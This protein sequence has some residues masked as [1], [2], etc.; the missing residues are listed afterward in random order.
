MLEQPQFGSLFAYQTG[1]TGTA[2][3]GL[4]FLAGQS[5]GAVFSV[6]SEDEIK[7]ASTAH[8]KRPWQ[9]KSIDAAGARDIL[10]AGRVQWVYPGQTITVV[11]RGNVDENIK[12][13]FQ[14][15]NETKTVTLTPTTIESELASRMYGQVSVGQLESLGSQVFDV[16]AAY[17]RHFRVTGKT[18]SLLMLESEADYERFDIKPKE[19]L[20]VVKAKS[21]SKLVSETL[22]KFAEQL[23][24][25]K[26][27]L[28]TWLSRLESMPGMQFKI[29]TALKLAMDDIEIEA[30]S[31]PLNCTLT[32]KS[33]L[34][35]SYLK[36]I[37]NENLDY[38]PISAEAN[39]RASSSVDDAIKV[40]SSLVE[41]NPSDII[42]ARDIAFTA[43][44][45]E[46]PAPAFHLLRR[47]ARARPFQGN[48]YPA[49]GQCLT[50]MGKADM[51][52]VYYEIAMNGTFQRQGEDFKQIV[53]AEYIHLLR[54]IVSG[55]L[56]SSVKDF[57]AARLETLGKHLPFGTADVVVTMM[58][59]Q[60][61]TDVDMHVVE[62]SGE[63]CYYKHKKTRS[64]GQITSDIT[65]GFGP[66]MY[67]NA[68]A[69]RGKYQLKA[70]FF[71]SG[72]NRTSTR[73]K[74]YVTIIRGFGT[75]SETIDRQTI[76]LSNVGEVEPVMTLGIE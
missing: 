74:V 31:Q 34:S 6:A 54:Q 72:Q 3:S 45:M 26:A 67:Y 5:G 65:T 41:R 18:C 73:N 29:P 75:D 36:T 16:S 38:D 20:F 40:Y 71:G 13:E 7:T 44:E 19:D 62:P 58:W 37:A 35:E 23:A 66:E 39:R 33:D 24:D 53:A 10:T 4:R 63:E 43:M 61:Q 64:G 51:A 27:K 69:P 52:I 15:A 57:A 70:K 1:L 76:Q 2:I 32:K 9:L 47:V 46:R 12:L 60:D 28:Q 30:I 11:G 42:V 25:P 68:N 56:K 55:K 14:Q 48:I 17:A 21:T 49:I 8:R 22:S 59:N 50:Q